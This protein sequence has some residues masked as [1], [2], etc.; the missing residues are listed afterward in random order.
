MKEQLQSPEAAVN[1]KG[2][3]LITLI[4]PLQPQQGIN[5]YSGGANLPSLDVTPLE[6]GDKAD[7][8]FLFLF[9]DPA[10]FHCPDV[11]KDAAG[12]AAGMAEGGLAGTHR[13]PWGSWGSLGAQKSSGSL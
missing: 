11:A 1:G 2:T 5:I 12:G 9:W 3:V 10:A 6:M 8:E 13:W 4:P 7:S